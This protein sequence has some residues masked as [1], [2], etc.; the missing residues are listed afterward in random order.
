MTLHSVISCARLQSKH[1]S[2]FI[3]NIYG[4]DCVKSF[5]LK[6]VA[7]SISVICIISIG[8][9]SALT[10]DEASVTT[11]P[12]SSKYYQGDTASFR[13][14]FQSNIADVLEITRVSIQ[15]DWMPSDGFYSIDLSANPV[16]IPSL[17]SYTFYLTDI[18]FL[19]GASAGS[20]SYF[21][22]IDYLQNNLTGIWDSPTSTIQ[23]HESNEK[24][25]DEQSPQVGAR[26]N[27][28]T[29]SNSEAQSLL[30]QANTE[31][32]NALKSANEEKWSEA[33]TSLRNASDYLD[34]ADAA[35]QGGGGQ[36]GGGQ[37]G[38]L[39]LY[40]IIAAIVIVVALTVIGVAVRRKRR[41]PEAP[42]MPEEPVEPDSAA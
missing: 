37:T 12:L 27:N 36:T 13:V 33:V 31:Y 6:L 29:Y 26:I 18:P 14:I 16:S 40:L 39:L 15:F 2:I 23:I 34:Q 22:S 41:E 20:H 4:G 42:E 24:I 17:G 38:D 30:Q 35:E 11:S 8:I 28:A 10:Q 3:D 25:Y 19:G 1:L 32:Y 5:P 21:V 9:V 7:I